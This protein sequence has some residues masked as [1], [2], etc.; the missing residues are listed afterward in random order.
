[1]AI[2]SVKVIFIIDWIFTE[3]IPIE[4]LL[5]SMLITLVGLMPNHQASLMPL[6]AD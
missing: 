5:H 2:P 1:M 6:R 4:L 3:I